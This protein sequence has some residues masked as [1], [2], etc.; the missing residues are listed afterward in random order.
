VAL[1]AGGGASVLVDGLLHAG[2]HEITVLDVS[3]A[4]LDVARARLGP[5]AGGVTWLDADVLDAALPHAAF[6]VWHDRAVFHFLTEAADRARYVEHVRHALKPGGHVV[7]ATFA[8]DGPTKCSG[9]PVVRYTPSALQA[10][11]GGQFLLVESLR[12][13]HVTPS[14]TTQAFVYCLFRFGTPPGRTS[15]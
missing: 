4:A 8:D 12:E 6:D 1:D 2:Y 5:A 14:G 7:I 15:P 13:A 9:L 3:A 10:A 11:F